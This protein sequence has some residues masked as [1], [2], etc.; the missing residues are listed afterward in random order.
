MDGL[1]VPHR[2]IRADTNGRATMDE[3]VRQGRRRFAGGRNDRS[4]WSESD[5]GTRRSSHK[6]EK[7]MKNLRHAVGAIV[8][9]LLATV[10]VRAAIA[11]DGDSPTLTLK[12]AVELAWENNPDFLQAEQRVEA[13]KAAVTGATGA[14]LPDVTITGS[15]YHQSGGGGMSGGNES[16][17]SGSSTQQT[18]DDLDA[19][20]LTATANLTVFDGLSNL[21][22]LRRPKLERRSEEL[23]RQW[24]KEVLAYEVATRFFLV[25]E[26][27]D[28]E[29]L[30]E[31]NVKEN[32]L[33][34]EQI[35][36]FHRAG[37]RPITDLYQQKAEM[38]QAEKQLLDARHDL[39]VNR[40]LLLQTLGLPAATVI[41]PVAPAPFVEN[42]DPDRLASSGMGE[43]ELP[44]RADLQAQ[45]L[46]ERAAEQQ[47]RE[48]RAGYWPQ[49]S[50][51]ATLRSGYNTSLEDRSFSEQFADDQVVGTVGVSLSIPLF[52]GFQTHSAAAQAA[53]NERIASL[54]SRRLA[55]AA[56]VEWGQAA[57]DYRTA[58]QQV[59]VAAT[60]AEAA[61]LAL[62][63]M[64]ERYAVGA[65]TLL[66]L[67]AARNTNLEAN[68]GRIRADYDLIE[69]RL[70]LA[71]G[72][73][74]ILEVLDALYREQ[75][76]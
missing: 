52:D 24:E 35:E 49:L 59:E 11:A 16:G 9:L 33:Q 62:A 68:D 2:A 73:G 23:T 70:A 60:Q 5:R 3:L 67:T 34:L 30:E 56:A 71:Y 17:M 76:Q 13:K 27:R 22:A 38:S 19:L 39:P 4:W 12:R 63:A 18:G 42:L 37:K 58:L 14:F 65:A 7:S 45:E 74:K 64:E 44:A 28:L 43:G 6:T 29:A 54:E 8:L 10:G 55:R 66:E 31:E 21:A 46:T 32:R 61:R 25:L 51:Y 1:S 26:N 72:E 41:D 57:A 53:A 75:A 36:I 48:A 47:V 69:K 50:L 20:D 15:A 40:M